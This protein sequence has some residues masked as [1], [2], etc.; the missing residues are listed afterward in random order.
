MRLI[1][2]H[3]ILIGTAVAFFAFYAF[4]EFRGV[5]EAGSSWRGVAALIA[6]A[7]LLIY[8][9]NLRTRDLPPGDGGGEGGQ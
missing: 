2:A 9:L 7:A 5:G 4:W 6:S 3:R 8:L 1:T